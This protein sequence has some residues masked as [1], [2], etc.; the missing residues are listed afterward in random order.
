MLIPNPFFPFFLA[1]DISTLR[2]YLDDPAAA[3]AWLRSLGATDLKRAHAALVGMAST[4]LTLDLLAII[5]SQLEEHL[6]RSADPDMALNNL[7]RFVAA[8][9]NPLSMGTLFERDPTA[10]PTLVQIFSTS[11]HFSDLLVL[12]PEVFDLLRLSE[13]VPVARQMLVEDLVAEV[14]AL[15]HEQ[16]VLRA[17]RRFKRRETLRI[18][19]GDIIREQSLHTITTQISYLAEAILEGALRAAWRRLRAQRGTPR[20][21]DGRQARFVVLG[22]GKLGGRELNYSSDIDLIFLYEGEGKTDGKR[23]ITNSEFFDALARELV[24][25]LTEPTDLGG[26]PGGHAAAPRGTARPDGRRRRGGVEL[27]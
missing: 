4:R 8:A 11:Q 15:D 16:M 18:A 1:M 12:D 23:P 5:C 3:A 26:V 13:G 7:E 9:R 22:M 20:D 14:E 24:R 21:A 27:L 6:S 2:R 10:L 19:Y 17:L 25:L